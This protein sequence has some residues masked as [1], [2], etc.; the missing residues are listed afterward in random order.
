VAEN[1]PRVKTTTASL[2][3]G[4]SLLRAATE[5]GPA[6]ADQLAETT[7]IPLSTAYRYLRT[8]RTYGFVTDVGGV[9]EPGPVLEP[10]RRHVGRA[11][12]VTL[13][14][15]S[16]QQLAELTGE[17]AV[18]V[19]RVGLHA[20]CVH[21]V[22]SEHSVRLAFRIGQALPLYAGAGQ[23]TLLAHAPPE[24]VQAVF[25]GEFQ[26]F[27]PNTPTPENLAKRLAS[28][29]LSGIATSRGEYSP[30]GVAI[31]AP[32]FC[33]GVLVC[34]LTAAGPDTRCGPRWQSRTR[35]VLQRLS[36]ALGADLEATRG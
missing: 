3:R 7:G 28:T 11:E 23:R 29:R 18:L 5:T 19:V 4:L 30:G 12:L 15:S 20:M 16:L 27:T 10:A 22:E 25:D 36:E 26:Q 6:R 14:A 8:L 1:T 34:S 21:Q 35:P 13:A 31:A 32:V 24:V 9:F 33:N 17:T 2:E